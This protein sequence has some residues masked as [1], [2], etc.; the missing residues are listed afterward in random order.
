MSVRVEVSPI[1]ARMRSCIA[2]AA[3]RDDVRPEEAQ[4]H[5]P[6]VGLERGQTFFQQEAGRQLKRD[7][8]TSGGH[9]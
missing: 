3:S 1:A 6:E 5:P 2:E 9:S 8:P 7:Q 4:G